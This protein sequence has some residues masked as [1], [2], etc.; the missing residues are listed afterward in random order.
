MPA[1]L[2]VN[3]PPSQAKTWFHVCGEYASSAPIP[4]VIVVLVKVP[5]EKWTI[6]GAK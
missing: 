3:L 4:P 2:P 1:E 5:Y 6:F